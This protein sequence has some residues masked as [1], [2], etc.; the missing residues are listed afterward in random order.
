MGTLFKNDCDHWQ[1][2]ID[3]RRIELSCGSVVEIF[4]FGQWLHGRIEADH[5]GYYLFDPQSGVKLERDLTGLKARLPVRSQ[6]GSG[7]IQ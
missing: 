2:N 3:D 6:S 4:A 7:I 1:F 5:A